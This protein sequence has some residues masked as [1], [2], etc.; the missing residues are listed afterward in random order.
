MKKTLLL[1][2]AIIGFVCYADYAQAQVRGHG[3]GFRPGFRIG[4][5][6]SNIG[7]NNLPDNVYRYRLG[8][9]AG[10]IFNF[11]LGDIFSIQ[12]EINY[13]QKGF[14]YGDAE[15]TIPG[16]NNPIAVTREGNVRYGYI[17]VPVL[18][19]T[20][21]GAFFFELGPQASFLVNT[22]GDVRGI[23]IDPDLTDTGMLP[24]T[25]DLNRVDF[26]LAAGLGFDIFGAMIGLRYNL[27]LNP[28]ETNRILSPQDLRHHVFQLSVGYIFPGRNQTRNVRTTTTY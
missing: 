27:G 4:A 22:A 6:Y 15:H 11:G 24:T 12:P 13:S 1:F 2:V 21:A 18:F 8:Y 5:N 23:T 19:K 9:H 20:Q 25:G 28:I 16:I 26:G 14:S 10:L 17:D 3:T 7:G